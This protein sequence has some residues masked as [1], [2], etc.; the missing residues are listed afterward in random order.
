M[1]FLTLILTK[2]LKVIGVTRGIFFITVN[3]VKT[4]LCVDV[5]MVFKRLGCLVE[6]KNNRY[7]DF[8]SFYCNH[9]QDCGIIIYILVV[10]ISHW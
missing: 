7:I 10:P 4:I 1:I 6:E 5:P 8:A 9:F 2:L 3:K